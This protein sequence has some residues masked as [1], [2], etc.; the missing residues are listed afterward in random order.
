MNIMKTYK[1]IPFKITAGVVIAAVFALFTHAKATNWNGADGYWN[2][3]GNWES[4]IPAHGDTVN[5]NN[6]GTAR[7]NSITNINAYY[8]YIGL[9]VG[10]SGYVV[11]EDG[12]TLNIGTATFRIGNAGYGELTVEN[13]GNVTS[14]NTLYFAREAG[15]GAKVT[16]NG[17]GRS[18]SFEW[19]MTSGALHVGN[20]GEAEF[21]LNHA[22]AQLPNYLYLGTQETGDGTMTMNGDSYATI[23]QLVVGSKGTGAFN[24]NGSSQ[25]EVGNGTQLGSANGGVGTLILSDSATFTNTG[26]LYVG[27]SG[28]GYLTIQD[29][30]SLITGTTLVSSGSAGDGV[31]TVTGNGTL[32]TGR[33]SVEGRGNGGSGIKIGENGKIIST[34]MLALLASSTMDILDE[35][36]VSNTNA[37]VGYGS[38]VKVSGSKAIWESAG[39]LYM[40]NYGTGTSLLIENGGTVKNNAGYIAVFAN[41]EASV[42]VNGASS[43]WENSSSMIVSYLGKGSLNIEDGTVKN[44]DAVIAYSGG[45]TGEVSISGSGSW[46]NSGYLV[47]GNGGSAALTLRDSALVSADEDFILGNSTGS[48][49]TLNIKSDAV[50]ITEV[51]G[52][53]PIEIAGG[54][55]AGK[56][57]FDHS[58]ILQFS[59]LITGANLSVTHSGSG[60]TILNAANTYAAGTLVSDGIAIAGNSSAFGSGD[61]TISGGT[62]KS[63]VDNVTVAS[64]L[65]DRGSISLIDDSVQTVSVADFS[66]LGGSLE[67]DILSLGSFDAILGGGNITLSGGILVLN[68]YDGFEGTLGVSG[69][70]YHIFDGFNLLSDYSLQITNYDTDNWVAGIN[71]EGYLF[72]EQKSIPEPS[73]LALMSLLAIGAAFWRRKTC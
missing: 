41:S 55:G 4:G 50:K 43:L 54:A 35:G 73:T 32:Y 26:S 9:T 60:T 44:T 52:S 59:N 68:G 67:I 69:N 65:M 7:I 53:S 11:V 66:M 16:V 37:T 46:W 63:T 49:G 71:T 40:G 18:E 19:L 1:F 45:T 72:F 64:L 29:D 17:S 28:R 25:V 21:I 42:T 48:S 30:A 47:I 20:A 14:A 12:G 70:S 61:L 23:R 10:G 38:A 27:Y 39:Y 5:I 31:I 2:V 3:S 56:V 8:V 62:L 58:G 33:V 15:S 13:G 51:D 24:L 34:G 22:S 6:G 57:N 36:Y